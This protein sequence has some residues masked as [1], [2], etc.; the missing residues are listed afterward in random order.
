LFL[1]MFGYAGCNGRSASGSSTT[2]KAR[3]VASTRP[4]FAKRISAETD[5]IYPELV[6]IRRDLHRHPEV[7]GKE[8]RTA[9]VVAQ[10]LK[11]LG[12][13]V[14]TGVGGHGVVGV[15]RGG[16]KGPVVAYR[17]DMDALP[18][19][20]QEKVPYRSKTPGVSHACGH[21][22]H[23]AVGLG[24]AQVLS[25]MR[26]D[27]P[28]TVKFI[29]QPAEENLTGA[30]RMLKAGVMANPS[31]EVIYALHVY[32]FPAGTIITNPG[33]GFPGLD[34]FTVELVGKISD[35]AV[36]KLL[37]G[38]RA[39][40]TVHP[41]KSNAAYQRMKT[42]LFKAKDNPFS[43]FVFV[44][45]SL[46]AERSVPG[47]LIIKGLFKAS[48]A[49]SYR[50]A[51]AQLRK[52]LSGLKGKV[53]VNLKFA[54]RFPDNFSHRKTAVEAV[55]PLQEILGKG[56]VRTAFVSIPFHGED[57]ALFLQKI[58]GAMF[59]LGASNASRGILAVLHSP[60]FAVDEKALSVGVKGMAAVIVHYLNCKESGRCGVL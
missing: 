59:Y 49:E 34:R 55:R 26:T 24:V 5:R 1:L 53:T 2:N 36:Q 6:R 20:I 58:P 40:G 22:V 31:P 57:F 39:I 29:F 21:D 27:L 28:G 56:A 11:K 41:P 32:D 7:S 46:D 14:R 4:D 45:T 16:R 17:A 9:G 50:S 10:R 47:K 33:V 12:L 52:V 54:P 13:E 15:L 43:R 23:T 51:R 38:I 60:R 44:R 30:A 48:D 42:F 8:V 19:P 35:S 37:T 3:P 25:S 18:Q